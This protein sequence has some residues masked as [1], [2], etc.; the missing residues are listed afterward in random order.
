MSLKSCVVCNSSFD[1]QGN[2]KTCNDCREN[3]RCIH[4]GVNRVKSLRNKFCSRECKKDFTRSALEKPCATCG[5][6]Y[7]AQDKN[8]S[9]RYCSLKCFHDSIKIAIQHTCQQCGN[10][11]TPN[12]LARSQ[13]YCSYDCVHLARR[14]RIQKICRYCGEHFECHAYR[15]ETNLHCSKQCFIA[16]N[17]G[18]NHPAWKGGSIN[19]YGPNWNQQ[20]KKVRKRDGYRCQHCGI[21]QKKLNRSLDIHHI[22]PFKE[23]G[24]IPGQNNNYK[25]ANELTNL[26]S[27]CQPCHRRAEMGKIPIQPR[28]L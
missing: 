1:A 17:V 28:L 6:V 10:L 19:S 13:K 22:R 14:K 21:S 4:C 25:K 27:L 18:P 11:F 15:E 12:T 24:Y 8:P 5:K 23:F 20:R 16:D 26:I 2:Q 7:K 9:R 3:K